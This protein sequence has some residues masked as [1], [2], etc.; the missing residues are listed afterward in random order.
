[1][2]DLGQI[3]KLIIVAGVILVAV[4]IL[5]LLLGRVPVIGRLPGDFVIRR[6]NVTIYVPLATMIL[7]SLLLTIILNLI[8]RR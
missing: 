3:G 4:G 2:T 7:I 6:D 1:M 8:F 5:F